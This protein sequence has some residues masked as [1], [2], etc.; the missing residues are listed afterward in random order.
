MKHLV[1]GGKRY[2]HEY[3]GTMTVNGARVG[4]AVFHTNALESQYRKTNEEFL[5]N[6]KESQNEIPRN[7]Q[8]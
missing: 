1:I 5:E 2:L 7:R 8:D 6:L 4:K 3:S